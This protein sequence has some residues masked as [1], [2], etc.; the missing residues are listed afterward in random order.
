MSFR[1]FFLALLVLPALCAAAFATPFGDAATKLDGEWH[2]DGFI[3]RIDAKRAQASIDL[4]H[5]F[6]WERFLVKEITPDRIVFTIGAELYE[7]ELNQDTLTLSGTSFS[8]DRV[9][10]REE[11]GLRGTVPQ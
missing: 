5:P 10:F 4:K 1:A 11:G 3:L 9:L 2:G 7:A 6:S 8:G